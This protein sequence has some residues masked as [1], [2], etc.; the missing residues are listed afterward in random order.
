MATIFVKP[1]AGMTIRIPGN[2]LE[3]LPVD[4]AEVTDSPFWRRRIKEGSVQVIRK[5]A[6]AA[7]K[8]EK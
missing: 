1:L 6:A 2:P 7:K 8:G 3:K 4:G 5:P